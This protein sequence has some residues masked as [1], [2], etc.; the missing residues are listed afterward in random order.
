LQKTNIS[1]IEEAMRPKCKG[2]IRTY[3]RHRNICSIRLI[4]KTRRKCNCSNFAPMCDFMIHGSNKCAILSF[5]IYVASIFN[6]TYMHLKKSHLY[7]I[8]RT[9]RHMTHLKKRILQKMRLR[10]HFK[11]RRRSHLI[12][13]CDLRHIGLWGV[14]DY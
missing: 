12:F 3:V 7:A 13:Q 11:L 10:S 6:A 4:L 8:R 5:C 14:G 9:T 1:P 2:H